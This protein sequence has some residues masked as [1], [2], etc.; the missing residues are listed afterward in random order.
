MG[1]NYIQRQ[2]RRLDST[3][4]ICRSQG[5]HSEGDAAPRGRAWR[6]VVA[7]PTGEDLEAGMLA[8]LPDRASRIREPDWLSG[9]CGRDACLMSPASPAGATQPHPEMLTSFRVPSPNPLPPCETRLR[10]RSR[11]EPRSLC[12]CTPV[13]GCW[14]GA[15]R[16]SCARP[17]LCH[18]GFLFHCTPVAF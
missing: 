13:G 15:Q 5:I 11:S 6:R 9:H 18:W 4:W 10:K 3:L 7:A 17:S 14:L 8:G 16:W 2:A 1:P 12:L